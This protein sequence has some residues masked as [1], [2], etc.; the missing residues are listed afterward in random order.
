MHLKYGFSSLLTSKRNC[1]CKALTTSGTLQI[2]AVDIRLHVSSGICDKDQNS[3]LEFDSINH[4]IKCQHQQLIGGYE[5]IY[6]SSN[7]SIDL[8]LHLDGDRPIVWIAIQGNTTICF[9]LFLFF[10]KKNNLKIYFIVYFD[11]LFVVSFC[12]KLINQF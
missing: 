10:A 6:N 12:L 4:V 11:S 3:Y 9:Y 1:K 5:T 2:Q 8:L 7:S